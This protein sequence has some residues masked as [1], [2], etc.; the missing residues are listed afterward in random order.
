MKKQGGW[1]TVAKYGTVDI[2]FKQTTAYT[3]VVE[4]AG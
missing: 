3:L 2:V 4:C 1:E